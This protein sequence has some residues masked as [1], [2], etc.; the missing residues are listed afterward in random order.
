[1]VTGNGTILRIPVSGLR[2]MGRATQGVRLINLRENDSIA[3]VG[4]VEMDT[5]EVVPEEVN[6]PAEETNVVENGP[7]FDD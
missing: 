1:M 2:V 4:Y 3:S 6:G 5:V 7:E